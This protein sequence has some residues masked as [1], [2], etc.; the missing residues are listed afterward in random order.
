MRP[1]THFVAVCDGCAVAG[2]CTV[3]GPS[4]VRAQIELHG[5][6]VTVA[7]L[8]CPS[9]QPCTECGHNSGPAPGRLCAACLAVACAGCG[10]PRS[11]HQHFPNG[12]LYQ[13][14]VHI[15]LPADG[16]YVDCRCPFIPPNQSSSERS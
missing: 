14:P 8:L 2:E 1:V 3:D 4:A 11:A 15:C 7:G 13:L 10:H 9:C 12:P 6:I 5:W 16:A